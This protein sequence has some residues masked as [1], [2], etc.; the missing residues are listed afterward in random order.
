MTWSLRMI[1]KGDEE[2]AGIFSQKMWM[3]EVIEELCFYW[4]K[5]IDQLYCP[6]TKMKFEN[7]FLLFSIGVIFHLVY[8]Y[9]IFDIYFKSPIVHGMQSHQISQQGISKRIV[10]IVSD[11]LRSDKLFQNI[12]RFPFFKSIT[13]GQSSVG[14][15]H[16]RVPTESRPCH[17]SMISGIYEDVSAVFNGWKVNPVEFDSVFNQSNFV[18]QI[19]SPDV[20]RIYKGKNMESHFYP[21]EMEDF[22]RD[23]KELDEWVFH[24]FH[25]ELKNHEKLK[26][27]KVILFLHLLGM[28][29]AGHSYKP[30]SPD[31]LNGIDFLDKEV[32]K[33]YQTIEELFPDKKT[34]YLFTADHGMTDRGS[35]G[36][37]D[38]DCTRTPFILW[39]NGVAKSKS[40]IQQ[41]D[42]TPMFS[43]FLG[44]PYPINNVG[45]TPISFLDSSEF[46][47]IE[48]LCV[49]AKQMF[50]QLEKRKELKKKSY[51]FSA[52]DLNWDDS[53]ETLLKSE[54]FSE[55]KEKCE[56]M[57]SESL[58]GMEYYQ[59]YDWPLLMSII[60]CGYIGWIITSLNQSFHVNLI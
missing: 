8:L 18:L 47:K 7:K 14:I 33:L 34:T 58:R 37:G 31:Y 13:E 32:K 48:N 22:S 59:K 45:K 50:S 29:S 54:K 5:R 9:S 49:N 38:P 17:V 20:V 19:G 56:K 44:V 55:A 12:D 36:D 6:N 24:K 4:I 27:E 25:K 52:F 41:V 16:T 35:H 40:E 3:V 2:E 26:Q 46:Y 21:E 10:F 53:I 43:S 23:P 28:D 42:M 11:G 1:S 57:I 60:T 51:F 15:S 39:G 30:T